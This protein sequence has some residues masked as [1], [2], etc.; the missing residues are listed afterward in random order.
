M[1]HLC[2]DKTYYNKQVWKVFRQNF[3]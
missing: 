3:S 2:T 1:Q